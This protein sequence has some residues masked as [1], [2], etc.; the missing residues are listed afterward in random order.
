MEEAWVNEIPS[1]SEAHPSRCT[2]N[3]FV[4]QLA[5]QQS[6]GAIKVRA[7]AKAKMTTCGNCGLLDT[8]AMIGIMAVRHIQLVVRGP[9]LVAEPSYT[10]TRGDSVTFRVVG[11]PLTSFSNWR[12]EPTGH[13]AIV[14]SENINTATWA[15]P[16]VLGGMA[17]V[18]VIVP[19]RLSSIS[20]QLDDTNGAPRPMTVNPRAWNSDPLAPTK[21]TGLAPPPGIFS[22]ATNLPG[23]YMGYFRGYFSAVHT[24]IKLDGDTPNKG[25]TYV[26]EVKHHNDALAHFSYEISPD[27][28]SGTTFYARQCGLGGFILNSVLRSNT[29][30][31]ES[32]TVK[33][34]YQQYRDKLAE[35]AVNYA[36]YA[37]N[38][39]GPV[40]W[41]KQ[42]FDDDLQDDFSERR[43]T[44]HTTASVEACNQ[45]VRYD[46]TC[47]APGSFRG[48]INDPPYAAPCQG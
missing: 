32:G 45:D 22:A 18:V 37:E 11:S 44:L 9:R 41:T 27:L 34:H 29:Y 35:P 43:E 17:R 47:P 36:K 14:R 25:L 8:S 30:S 1:C 2:D 12:Y 10:V 33:G 39:I 21:T 23:A 20:L 46:P 5:P 38:R 4:L 3:T 19:G 28:E 15:G 40:T 13:A 6:T 24:S 48:N 42:Q 16:L 31:H 7:T 26:T